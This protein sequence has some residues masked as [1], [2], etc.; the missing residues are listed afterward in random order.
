LEVAH[1]ACGPVEVGRSWAE[2]ELT[3]DARA[4]LLAYVGRI[5][6]IHP[7]DVGLLRESSLALEDR[8]PVELRALPTAAQPRPSALIRQRRE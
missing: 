4:V 2:V 5:V 7:G 8:R 1:F 6:Q 3:A